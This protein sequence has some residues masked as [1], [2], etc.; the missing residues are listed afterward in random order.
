MSQSAASTPDDAHEVVLPNPPAAK[1]NIEAE[2]IKKDVIEPVDS[3][4]STPELAT[5]ETVE[6]SDTKKEPGHVL[7]PVASDL[8]T[9]ELAA[10]CESIALALRS[11]SV[12][13]REMPSVFKHTE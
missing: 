13:A 9:Q 8:S 12:V 11:S 1:E 2:G 3:D 10:T 7:E 4:I 5:K 6:V